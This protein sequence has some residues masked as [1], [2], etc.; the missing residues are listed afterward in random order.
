[1]LASGVSET[2]ASVMYGAVY[3]F[4]PR[5]EKQTVDRAIPI[6]EVQ[7]RANQYAKLGNDSIA[8]ATRIENRRTIEVGGGVLASQKRTREVADLV[9]RSVPKPSRFRDQDF[10]ALRQKIES[11]NLT[12]AQIR[13][14][15]P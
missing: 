6:E 9:V 10:E 7:D 15:T 5:W 4:G 8:Y 12:P 11:G 2:L 3:H 1:M 14:L 13:A